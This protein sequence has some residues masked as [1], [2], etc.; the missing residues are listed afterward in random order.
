MVGPP[1]LIAI[2]TIRV[3]GANRGTCSARN[4]MIVAD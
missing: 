3:R 1:L 4:K 2:I